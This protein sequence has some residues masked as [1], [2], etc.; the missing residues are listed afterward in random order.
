MPSSGSHWKGNTYAG[1]ERRPSVHVAWKRRRPLAFCSVLFPFRPSV[2][3]CSL[4]NPLLCFLKPP[5]CFIA[6]LLTGNCSDLLVSG[7]SLCRESFSVGA[8]ACESSEAG[9]VKLNSMRSA[10]DVDLQHHLIRCVAVYLSAHS[11]LPGTLRDP[12]WLLRPVGVT[13]HVSAPGDC[14]FPKL[15]TFPMLLPARL[16]CFCD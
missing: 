11:F 10:S 1:W 3:F 5:W 13:S 2:R 15:A 7:D 6:S 8:C 14:S 9:P 4:G 16:N 12:T